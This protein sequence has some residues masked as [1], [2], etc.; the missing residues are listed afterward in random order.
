M[1]TAAHYPEKNKWLIAVAVVFGA[2]LSVMDI[3]VVNV[4]LPH[5]MGNF[6]QTLSAIT[7]VATSY[8]IAEIIMV[9]MTGWLSTLIGRKRLYLFSFTLFT[10]G[11]MLCGTAHTFGQMLV[12]RVIQGI[13]GGALIPISQAVL[14]ETFPPKEQGLAMAFFGMGVVLAPAIGP[15]IGGWLTDQYG[16]PWIF[17]I[18]IPFSLAGMAMI[19]AYVHDPHYLK[20]GV[21]EVDWYGILFLSLGLTGLQVVLERGQENNWFE[22]SFITWSTAATALTLAA[23]IWWEFRVKEPIVNFRLLKDVRLSVGSAIVF[24]FGI[25]L[26]G[27]TFVLPQFTQ[28]LL[29][30]PAYEAGL[31]L[32]PRAAAL[33]LVMPLVG[34]LYNYINARALIAFGIVVIFASYIGLAHLSL[35]VDYWNLIPVLVLMGLGM[36][37]MFV[38]LSTAALI[39][40]PRNEMTN[41]S[42]IYT[43][44]QRI[45]GNVGYAFVATIIERRSQ[46]HRS[47]LV[48]SISIYNQAFRE[49]YQKFI[50]FFEQQGMGPVVA[51]QRVL[52]AADRL[53][54]RQAHMMAYNDVS[55]ILGLMFLVIL[56]LVYFLPGRRPS[57]GVTETVAH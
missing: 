43:L 2:F 28:Q 38:T 37:F 32:L 12:Y 5:M 24:L 44:F 18:N 56:P 19:A 45:G 14:R 20:R 41:A 46:F 17:Y 57:H 40:I 33:F 16:W 23:F 42:G 36:P 35:D 6:G 13:G 47:H 25:A 7:W 49:F 11:S 54:E 31:V 1:D 15:V 10:I 22:S 3:S 26:Y 55:W 48:D 51:Q 9:T 52:A 50:G 21:K 27:T 8:S 34:V 29:G 53:V 4:A 39:S 30:Y